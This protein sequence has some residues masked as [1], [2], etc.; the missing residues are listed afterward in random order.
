MF[1]LLKKKLKDAI[2]RF[3]RKAEES[4]EREEKAKIEEK[5]AEEKKISVEK[6]EEKTA[7]EEKVK[8]EVKDEKKAPEE[9]KGFFRKLK[10][11]VSRRVEEDKVLEKLE[12]IEE[13][14]EEE[15]KPSEDI[16]EAAKPEIEGKK[17]LFKRIAEKITT[18]RISGDKFEELFWELEVALMENNVAVEVIEKIK[19]DLKRELVENPI[20]RGDVAKVIGDSLRESI[21]EVLNVESFDFIERVKSKKLFVVCFIGVN[22]SGKTTTIAKVAELLK[23]NK[24]SCVLAAADTFRAAAIEQLDEHAQRLGVKI[25]KHEYGSDSAAVAF[26]A[27]SHARARGVDAVLI[28][29]AGRLHSNKDLMKELEKVVRVAKPDLKIFVGESIT[30]NDCVA[31]AREF[32]EAIGI[33]AI[34]LAK[35]DVDDKGGAAVSVGYVTKKPILYLGVGQ[36]YADLER[37]D[38]GKVLERLF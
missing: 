7:V 35:A 34:I 24:L 13:L 14:I 32:N 9:K 19:E 10:K 22:G 38:S 26:D 21:K 25:I 3:S 16:E 4:S 11:I 33:D 36:G 29:T 31:Q 5:P 8:A 17:G 30:G 28:D 27:I 23:K 12:E 2:G 37:F 6:I 1:G 15:L 18:T 20:K